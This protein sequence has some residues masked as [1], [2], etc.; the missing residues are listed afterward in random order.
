MKDIVQITLDGGGIAETTMHPVIVSAS[1]ST[2]IPAF[3]ADWFFSR[4]RRGYSAW[5]NPFNNKKSYVSYQDTRFIVFWSKNPNPLL[6]YLA[7]LSMRSIG[8][9]IQFTLNDYVH[10]GLE[11]NVPSVERRIDTFKR[12]VDKLGVGHVIW[13]FDPLVLTDRIS[14]DVLL[15]RI[16]NIGDQLK[17]YTEKLVFSFADISTYRMVK[18]NL[19]SAGINY[20]EWREDDM[21]SF[22][23]KLVELNKRW[24]YTLA[25]C[26]EKIDLPGIEHN[27]CVDHDL[28]IRLAHR[29]KALMDYLGVTKVP[30]QQDMFGAVTVPDGAILLDDGTMA[31]QKKKMP[32]KGQRQACGC[33]VSKDIGQYNTCIHQCEYCY[34]N[35]SKEHAKENWIRHRVFP[36]NELIAPDIPEKTSTI[37]WMKANDILG[38]CQSSIDEYKKGLELLKMSAEQGCVKA[39]SNLAHRL[40]YGIGCDKDEK[41]ALEWCNKSLSHPDIQIQLL[42]KPIRLHE[43]ITKQKNTF[44]SKAQQAFYIASKQRDFGLF[45]PM[46]DDNVILVNFMDRKY[47]QGKEEISEWFMRVFHPGEDRQVSLIASER[48]GMLTEWYFPDNITSILR[49]VFYIRTNANG[50]VDRIARQAIVWDRYCFSPSSTPFEWEEIEP[51]LGNV[52]TQHYNG[53]GMFCM[54]CGKLSH[55]LTWIHFE[56]KSDPK[57]GISYI[58]HM[59]VCPDCKRQVEFRC[60]DVKWHRKV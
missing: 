22:A 39:Q 45:Y 13:R 55:E 46:L 14:E 37:T 36:R 23:S 15:E 40:Y 58:G 6:P 1:R 33:M 59:S 8:C 51:W 44:L 19:R 53:G 2:D 34:A 17:G 43:V 47:R 30:V 9:Y 29:D 12:L 32:D 27:H 20:R 41:G 16:N 3:Y 38:S 4:L 42:P 25:T 26:G 31:I 60:E 54:E 21:L 18:N 52:D 35:T 28:I 57:T 50:K 5:I 56:S 24:G 7:E 10:D 48:Y 49:S 11:K